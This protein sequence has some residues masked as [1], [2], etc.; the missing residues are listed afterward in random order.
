MKRVSIKVSIINFLN[1]ITPKRKI[2]LFDSYP[3]ISD[4][5]YALYEYIINNRSDLCAEYRMV[6]AKKGVLDIQ[7]LKLDTATKMVEKKSLKGIF[8]FLRAEYVVSTHGYFRGVRS[9]NGQLQ[10]NLWHG[11]GYKDMPPEDRGYRGDL[12]IVTSEMYRDIFAEIFCL[13]KA[14]VYVT[15]YPRN[16]RLFTSK[17]ILGKLNIIKGQFAKVILWMPTFR[18]TKAEYSKIDGKEESMT[19]FNLNDEQLEALNRI[20]TVKNYIMIVKAHPMDAARLDDLKGFNRIRGFT[21]DDLQHFGVQ[22]YELLADSDV[23]LSDYSSVI[24]DYLL[25]DKPISMILSDMEEYKES[26]GFLFEPL[27]E[28]LPGPIIGS[29]EDL[30]FYF[31]HLDEINGQWAEK[32]KEITRIMHKY[33]DK[34][35][36]QRVAEVIWGRDE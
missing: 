14:D 23:L 27:E 1:Q 26:R 28:Y 33:C 2:I 8:Y 12:T 21:S 31:E 15:G 13:D 4:N 17:P 18:K 34:Y 19:P 6:W 16:D 5:S 10:V 29:L 9:G 11:C 3:N 32:R 35:S 36:A 25:L 7:D 30:L 20:L 24:V 22:L